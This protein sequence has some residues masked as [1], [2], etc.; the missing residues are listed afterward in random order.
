VNYHTLT[1]GASCLIESSCPVIIPF[2]EISQSKGASSN[3]SP[4]LTH[5]DYFLVDSLLSEEFL[6]KLF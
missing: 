5:L 2:A 1:D 3:L 4:L 6:N